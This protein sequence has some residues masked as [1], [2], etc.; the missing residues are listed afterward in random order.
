M[1]AAEDVREDLGY[2][3]P[4]PAPRPPPPKPS[5]QRPLELKEIAV[6]RGVAR[7]KSFSRR[8]DN[9]FALSLLEARKLIERNAL[10]GY[11]ITDAGVR[12]LERLE[13]AR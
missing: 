13:G 8:T 10:D 2:V 9:L 5:A 7:G 4:T 1:S 11:Q 3:T 12:A 6:L